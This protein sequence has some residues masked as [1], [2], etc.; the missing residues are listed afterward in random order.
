MHG[1][2]HQLRYQGIRDIIML[3]GDKRAVAREMAHRFGSIGIMQKPCLR[4]KQ[5]M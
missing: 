1:S 2:V 3:T 4:I 5:S